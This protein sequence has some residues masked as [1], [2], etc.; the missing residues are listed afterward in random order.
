LCAT[1]ACAC[2]ALQVKLQIDSQVQ[3]TMSFKCSSLSCNKL[4]TFPICLAARRVANDI[5]T[6]LQAVAV[7]DRS[8]LNIFSTH[9]LLHMLICS[10][11]TFYCETSSIWVWL[12]VLLHFK[13]QPHLGQHALGLCPLLTRSQSRVSEHTLKSPKHLNTLV[14]HAGGGL[15][16]FYRHPAV[17]QVYRNHISAMLTRCAHRTWSCDNAIVFAKS[18]ESV[19]LGQD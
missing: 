2:C 18:Y 13:T 5:A 3:Q 7:G 6:V 11:G 17:R 15:L 19:T 16:D 12:L 10:I 9:R 8:M 4:F 1:H 14:L